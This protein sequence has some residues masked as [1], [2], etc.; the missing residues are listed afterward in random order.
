MESGTRPP[1]HSKAA[2]PEQTRPDES[3]YSLNENNGA[4]R[5]RGSARSININNNKVSSTLIGL[6]RYCPLMD[7]TIV[8][9]RFMQE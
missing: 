4:P 3:R 5:T 9:P 2:L 7:L 6:S 1:H 8:L